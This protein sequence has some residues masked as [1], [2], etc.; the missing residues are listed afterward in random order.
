MARASASY[1]KVKQRRWRLPFGW[2]TH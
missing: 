2:V 1:S